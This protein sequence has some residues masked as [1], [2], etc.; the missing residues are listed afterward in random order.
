MDE[1]EADQTPYSSQ[2]AVFRRSSSV[3]EAAP[4]QRPQPGG[5][6]PSDVQI[7]RHLQASMS[8]SSG[9]SSG[10]RETVAD[11]V[12]LPGSGDQHQQ[13]NAYEPDLRI[14]AYNNQPQQDSEHQEIH[15]AWA[16]NSGPAEQYRDHEHDRHF[17]QPEQHH[18]QEQSVVSSSQGPMVGSNQ[19]DPDRRE[20]SHEPNAALD[21]VVVPTYASSNQT[22]DGDR[23]SLGRQESQQSQQTHSTY[24]LMASTP[25]S[26]T[27]PPIS[28]SGNIAAS[29]RPQPYSK[30][31]ASTIDM[32]KMPGNYPRQSTG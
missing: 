23:R 31:N 4:A 9:E 20:I 14:I 17:N 16:G 26:E 25:A 7:E 29:T 8:L 12:A 15:G 11:T 18:P 30:Q 19:A 1:D 21:P 6:F 24:S 27:T 2:S 3:K 32:F 13:Q 10:A 28:D 5:R 22:S